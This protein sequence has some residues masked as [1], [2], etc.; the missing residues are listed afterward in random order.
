MSI[1]IEKPATFLALSPVCLFDTLGYFRGI[2]NS[3]KEL[4]LSGALKGFKPR[5]CGKCLLK[6]GSIYAPLTVLI[7]DPIAS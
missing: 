5:L 4:S 2:A 1:H 6:S 3:V 7:S